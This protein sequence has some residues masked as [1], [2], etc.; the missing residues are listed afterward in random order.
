MKNKACLLFL[1]FIAG[2]TIFA[3]NY[4]YEQLRTFP[5]E[6][7]AIYTDA[8]ANF[9][10]KHDLLLKKY[11][12]DGN[13]IAEYDSEFFSEFGAVDVSDMFRVLVFYPEA[14][15]LAILDEGIQ[16]IR[17]TINFDPLGFDVEAVCNDQNADGYWI[18]DAAKSQLVHL[19]H[20]TK[21][22]QRS[23]S[24]AKLGYGMFSPKQ[25][26]VAEGRVYA[27]DP[28]GGLMIFDENGR[29]LNQQMISGIHHATFYQGQLIWF[30]NRMMNFY[31][32]IT[33]EQNE[34]TLPG[35]ALYRGAAMN[36]GIVPGHIYL[37]DNSTLYIYSFQ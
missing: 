13:F 20:S 18:Y 7:S 2:T 19:A 6:A 8:D 33:Q 32:P 22:L 25:L 10:L 4:R 26:L 5:A 1:F 9:Y 30:A 14:N 3:Q 37:F 27:I 28:V 15:M 34:T 16:N 17:D 24:F 12:Q 35:T 31:N 29:F 21:V 36:Y 11:D 23:E